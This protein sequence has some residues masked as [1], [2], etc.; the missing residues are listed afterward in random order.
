MTKPKKTLLLILSVSLLTSCNFIKN[1]FTYK[2]TT[3]EFVDALIAEDYDKGLSYLATEHVAYQDANRDSLKIGLRNFGQLIVDNFGK[4]LDY[5][6]MTAHKTFSTIEG[7]STAPNTTLARIEFANET[8]FG[9]FEIIFDDSTNKILRIDTLDVKEPIPDMTFFW[10]VGLLAICVP[11][12]NIWV[13]RKIK[14]SKVKRKWLKYL[15]VLIFNVPS[16]TYNAVHGLSF[17]LLSFQVLFGIGFY[18]MGYLGSLWTV[19]VP[20]GG[21]YWLWRLK[22][23]SKKE[24]AEAK[25]RAE[26]EAKAE[27][28]PE[29]EALNE[30]ENE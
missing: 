11:I 27:A 5:K 12:F 21:V 28:E 17:S 1:A 23:R 18:Y 4:E 15:G 25:A 2:D 6:F 9:V 19:G 22:V 20:L 7:Q 13:I 10:L 29:A 8:E 14:K 26:V 30:Q 24:A 3:E 16:F